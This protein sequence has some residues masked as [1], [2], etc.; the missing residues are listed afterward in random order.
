[1][2]HLMRCCSYLAAILFIAMAFIMPA[3]VAASGADLV[4]VSPSEGTEIAMAIPGMTLVTTD[5]MAKAH[6]SVMKR[7]VG[8]VVTEDDLILHVPLKNGINSYTTAVNQRNGNSRP[9]ERR[10]KDSQTFVPVMI[11]VCL[12]KAEDADGLNQP[13]KEYITWIDPAVFTTAAERKSLETVFHSSLTLKEGNDII[14]DAIYTSTY[15]SK[16]GNLYGPSLLEQGYHL[17]HGMPYEFVGTKNADFTFTLPSGADIS[18]I[19]GAAADRNVAI[20]RIHG[21][22]VE[23][24]SS[25]PK[26]C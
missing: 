13:N 7:F 8:R 12:Q 4:L 5:P 6:S 24:Q 3:E 21:F 26:V 10:L 23:G 17:Y 11:S 15:K 25:L 16:S 20:I 9:G 19:E 18:A 14:M 22:R 2:K 1:M